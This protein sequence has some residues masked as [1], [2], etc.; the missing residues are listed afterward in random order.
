M[1]RA[2]IRPTRVARAAIAMILF[3]VGAAGSGATNGARSAQAGC[4]DTTELVTRCEWGADETLMTWAP[5]FYPAQKITIHHTGTA[6]GDVDPA[7]TVRAI[8]RHQA[9]DLGFGDI[10]YQYLIDENGRV[11]EGRYSGDDPYPGHD[12]TGTKVVTGAHV[13]GSNSGNIGIALI[14]TLTSQDATIAARAALERLLREL[15]M[16]YGIAPQG[17]SLYV[18]PV[19]GTTRDVANISGHRDWAASECPGGTFYAQ[20]P[21]IRAAVAGA[22]PPTDTAAPIISGLT[23]VVKN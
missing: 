8:Y 6:N 22:A 19:D 13:A 17:A 21:A 12:S 1:M 20:L 15:V 16:R 23:A 2:T 5:E 3:A 18:N 14:G 10:G 7:A 9:V 4:S 11:Y